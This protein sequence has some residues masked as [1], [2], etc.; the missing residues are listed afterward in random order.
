MIR[1]TYPQN[2]RKRG[3]KKTQK[4]PPP[5]LPP[6]LFVEPVFNTESVWC[7]LCSLQAPIRCLCFF[8]RRK[9]S[10][11]EAWSDYSKQARG[12]VIKIRLKTATKCGIW[13]FLAV[14]KS[15]FFARFSLSGSRCMSDAI[16]QYKTGPGG[17]SILVQPML[18]E[19]MGFKPAA[20]MWND[21]FPC[22]S[23]DCKLL[24]EF[25]QIQ[26]QYIWLDSL[27]VDFFFS[28]F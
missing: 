13:T 17:G 27:I 18:F 5:P 7:W 10:Y 14:R 20:W 6:S 9:E 1:Q 12:H 21:G 8:L 25:V 24:I 4:T 19:C 11:N 23:V 26:H 3:K 28:M 15:T 16:T 22:L 2:P